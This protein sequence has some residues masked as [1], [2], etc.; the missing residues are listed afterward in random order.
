VAFRL[1]PH[2]SPADP[3]FARLQSILEALVA[4]FKDNLEIFAQAREEVEAL[5]AEEDRR[6]DLEA[7]A[8]ARRVE[9]MENLAVAKRAA[10]EEVKA[11]VQAHKL[12]G[13]VLEFLV[14]QWLKLLL[15]IHV[16]EGKESA[17]W[18]GAVETM[19]QLIWSIEPKT[20][21]EE[22]AKFVAVIP[23][24]IKQLAVGLKAAGIDG[25]VRS[26]FF[27]ELMKYHQQAISVP[28]DPASAA[29]AAPGEAGSP[30]A[31]SQQTSVE[32]NV[33]APAPPDFTAP[34][35][36]RNPFGD[37]DVSV[38]SVDLDFTTMEAG[39]AGAA[40]TPRDAVAPN[41]LTN[42]AVGQWV[43]F[44]EN[45]EKPTRRSGRLIFVTPRKTRYL[46]AFDRAGKDI[47]PYSPGEMNRR[48]RVGDAVLIGE[49][50]D[51]SLFDRIMKGLVG[52]LRASPTA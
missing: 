6:A 27:G 24:L 40:R 52:K 38:D 41:P 37:G 19:D 8:A 45:L 28:G 36:V 5:L 10:A 26:Q 33:A 16:K 49:P 43:E 30:A 18:K 12:P 11:R 15:L 7:R 22:R 50:R 35:T 31:D 42:L 13:T 3:L 29:Q 1:P 32:A 44:R 34:I 17:A 9:E 51:E 46:F 47:L 39:G 48:F 4:G 20:T 14:Q 23:G 25:Y 2:F 21:R